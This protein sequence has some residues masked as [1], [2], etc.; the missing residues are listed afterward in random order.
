VGLDGSARLDESAPEASALITS[1]AWIADGISESER[2]AAQALVDLGLA[3][4]ST[5]HVFTAKPWIADWLNGPEVAVVQS[6]GTIA[7][8]HESVA[9]DL[10]AKP[11]LRT[12]EAVDAFLLDEFE[13][14]WGN[15]NSP[16][17][18]D[19]ADAIDV[20][21]GESWVADGLD[22]RERAILE[23]LKGAQ[24]GFT[25]VYWRET[26]AL[27]ISAVANESWVTDGL[28]EQEWALLEMFT[29]QNWQASVHFIGALPGEAWVRDGLDE[30]ERFL[31]QL[32]TAGLSAA[33]SAAFLRFAGAM[34]GQ[35]WVRD[36]LT[37]PERWLLSALKWEDTSHGGPDDAARL[38]VLSVLVSEPWFRDGLNEWD[39]NHALHLAATAPTHARH[40]LGAAW[41]QDGMDENELIFLR[42]ALADT[43]GTRFRKMADPSFRIVVEE[44]V[45][46]L[47]LSGEVPLVII[48]TG[49]GPA[50][51]MDGLEYAVR[52]V[53]DV[54]ER[55]LPVPAVRLLFNPFEGW[56]G[57][58]GDHLVFPADTDGTDWLDIALVHEVAHY[59]GRK[60]H[61]WASEGAASTIEDLVAKPVNGRPV[62]AHNYPCAHA[63]GIA[64]LERNPHFLCNYSL[65][66]RIFVD[67]YRALGEE[68][69]LQGFRDFH[70]ERFDIHGFRRAF[71]S[72]APAQA[73]AVDAVVDRWYNGPQP[74]GVSLPDTGPVSPVLE[75][76]RGRVD[77]VDL[78]LI[79]G[80][81][82][83]PVNAQTAAQ[84]VWIRLEFSFQR[85]GAREVPMTIIG[86]FEDGFT[87]R[88]TVHSFRIEEGRTEHVQLE[89][90][91]LPTSGSDLVSGQYRLDFYHED[92]KVAEA[93]F[94]ID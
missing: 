8:N 30:S 64:E 77:S 60:G 62:D 49:P 86:Y 5:L 23:R 40:I 48:R 25:T 76:L 72:A 39:R 32:E 19:L 28:D 93:A 16:T 1:L 66:K 58:A 38:L 83:V 29:N 18:G 52:S 90:L 75:G 46:T 59:Y 15:Y 3:Q 22:E 9:L 44:R 6:L 43:T 27:L 37:A 4:A 57:N 61:L 11:F 45:I 14:E 78:V 33:E 91:G 41:V 63:A 89:W 17:A 13:A 71:A 56:A 47:P 92:N 10:V 21:A 2:H 69:F 50:R 65:G 67:M 24:G 73:D 31:L 68:L 82:A 79:D 51:S 80:S 26:F 7:R 55:T 85:P 88:R 87:F 74:R 42:R 34:A 36:G 84:G 81:P 70:S 20:L 53:E 35:P 94:E 54:L 12:V